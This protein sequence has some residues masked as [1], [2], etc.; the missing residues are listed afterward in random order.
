[1]YELCAENIL[2]YKNYQVAWSNVEMHAL[3]RP[4]KYKN[5]IH[6]VVIRSMSMFY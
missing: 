3:T 6:E 2:N 5:G 4:C 1:M